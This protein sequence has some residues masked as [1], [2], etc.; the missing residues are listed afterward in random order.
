M[1]YIAIIQRGDVLIPILKGGD[2][3]D[4]EC[5]A[6]WDEHDEAYGAAVRVPISNYGE[7]MI[8]DTE[9]FS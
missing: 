5:L 9:N 7:I 2:G 6:Q 8:F 1:A 4:A 3:S